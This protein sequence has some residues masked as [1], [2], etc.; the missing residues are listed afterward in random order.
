MSMKVLGR[1]WEELRRRKNVINVALHTKI[2]DGKDT[3]TPAIV[4]YV[5]KKVAAVELSAEHLV[6]PEIEGVPTDVIE[7]PST[8]ITTFGETEISKLHPAEQIKRLGAN[9]GNPKVTVVAPFK[10]TPSGASDLTSKANPIQ[11][12][13]NCGACL[14][15]DVIGVWEGKLYII[16][17]VLK[18]FSEGH[19]F[20]C[21]AVASCNGGSSPDDILTQALKGIALLAD[22]PYTDSDQ[23][24]GTG[25][26]PTWWQRGNKL[27][28]QNADQRS[29][30][31]ARITGHGTARRHFPGTAVFLQL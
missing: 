14:A 19:L 10:G 3:G 24:C 7:L 13:A 30:R 23:A 4:V 12:Q 11:N 15:F 18:K 2:K 27:A 17:G 16:T 6:P 20:F 5:T 8:G 31:P 21:D 28:G 9:A 1:H 25:L 29:N 22:C 26:N